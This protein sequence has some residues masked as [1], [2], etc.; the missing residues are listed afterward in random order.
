M[1]AVFIVFYF[2]A[3]DIITIK[4]AALFPLK[5][6]PAFWHHN[7]EHCSIVIIAYIIVLVGKYEYI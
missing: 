3:G 1:T 2:G 5:S 7:F 6:A 4:S